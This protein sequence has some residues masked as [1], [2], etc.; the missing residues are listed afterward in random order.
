MDNLGSHKV[1]GV[2]RAIEA[3]AARLLYLPPYSPYLN[4]VEQA[5]AKLKAL[6][7]AKALRTVDALWD[8]LGDIP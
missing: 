2:R 4:P 7:P 1:A 3:A 5:F 6:L 8:A